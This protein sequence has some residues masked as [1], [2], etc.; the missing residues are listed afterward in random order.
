MIH[1]ED[2]IYAEIVDVL[3]EG[4][5]PFFHSWE[6]SDGRFTA[7]ISADG[8]IEK[9]VGATYMGQHEYLYT[10]VLTSYKI[11]DFKAVSGEETDFDL[12]KVE[13]ELES[14]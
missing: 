14:R 5:Y 1:V 8:E 9:S 4:G 12:G 2:F 7:C 10:D 13:K 3:L 11:E 6:S